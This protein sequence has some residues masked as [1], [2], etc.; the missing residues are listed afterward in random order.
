MARSGRVPSIDE[1]VQLL[2]AANEPEQGYSGT[3]TETEDG[4][5]TRRWR[6][7]RLRNLARVE[8][9]PGHPVLAAGET[10]YW[11][12]WPVDDEPVRKPRSAETPFDFELSHL[13]MLEPDDY[14]RTWLT[15]DARRVEDSLR[16]VELHGRRAWRFEVADP[17]AVL[18]VD[19]ELGLLLRAEGGRF[20]SEWSQVVADP[21]LDPEFFASL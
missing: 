18:W 21:D 6:V 2:A 20:V 19:A 7:W 3:L 10:H 14:W 12:N 5:V 9:P 16:D 15:H 8:D 4:V 13:A 1:L 17:D 11:R